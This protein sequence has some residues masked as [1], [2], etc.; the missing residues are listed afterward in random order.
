M[1]HASQLLKL[2]GDAMGYQSSLREDGTYGVHW[3]PLTNDAQAMALVKA[4]QLHIDHRPGKA[5]SVQ[6]PHF[7]VIA[8]RKDCNLNL[9]IVECVAKMR[10]AI[11]KTADDVRS[12]SDRR[13]DGS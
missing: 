12:T 11:D 9:A 4:L 8:E 7:T 2:C 6:D 13:N 10:V 5:V 3:N 1:M